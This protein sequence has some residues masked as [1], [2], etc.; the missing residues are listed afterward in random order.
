MRISIK[1]SRRK[2]FRRSSKSPPEHLG[3]CQAKETP[4]VPQSN[5]PIR[6]V[7]LVR[8]KVEDVLWMATLHNHVQFLDDCKQGE[9]S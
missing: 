1:S 8:R 9:G 6:K 7:N 4:V 3:V 2:L 5:G